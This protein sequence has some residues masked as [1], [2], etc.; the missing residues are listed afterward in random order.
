M[1]LR[2]SIFALFIFLGNTAFCRTIEVYDTGGLYSALAGSSPGDTLYLKSGVYQGLFEIST[3]ATLI[4]DTGSVIDGR[5]DGDVITISADSVVLEGIMVRNSGTRLL[6]D[7]SGLK[8][9]GNYVTISGCRIEDCLHGVY[10]KGGNSVNISN[11]VIVGRFNIQEADRGNGIHLWSTADNIIEGNDISFARDGIYFS[12]ANRT[13]VKNNHIHNLRYALHYMYSDDNYFEN[14]IFDHNVAGSALMYSKNIE[15]SRNVFAHCRGFR[16]YGILL[17]S[18]NYCRATDNL[19][20]DNTRG[21]FFD[22]ANYCSFL[23]NDIVQN[24]LALQI[25]AS[26]EEN[27]FVGNNFISNLAHCMLDASIVD[28]TYWS[29][30]GKGNFWSDYDGY[31]LDGNGVGDIPHE[32]QDVFE[33]IE[34]NHPAIR[35]YLY[36]PAS[37]LLTAAEKRIPILR[38]SQIQDPYPLFSINGK[39]RVP[40]ENSREDSP[41]VSI[42]FVA[43]WL[44]VAGLP[45]TAIV[46]MRKW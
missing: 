45:A 31:D 37:Q 40:W 34:S 25:K 26:C 46:R 24:D 10:V 11:N 30:D 28:R 9:T 3:P 41:G 32:L 2:A 6:K 18:V 43:I 38:K 33:Y 44:V 13:T 20:L 15:F 29:K 27:S 23:E 22:D 7:M 42:S 21:I 16:A 39:N 36:S 19:I 14:N 4:G 12:F 5:G 17:Q 35:F 8:V 1:F